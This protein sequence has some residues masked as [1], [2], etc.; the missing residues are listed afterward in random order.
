MRSIFGRCIAIAMMAAIALA[1]QSPPVYADEHAEAVGDADDAALA[2]AKA[3]TKAADAAETAAKAATK[4]ADAADESATEA[5]DASKAAVAADGSTAD[6]KAARD[7]ATAARGA[8]TAARERAGNGPDDAGDD[9]AM[10]IDSA[11]GRYL[12]ALDEAGMEKND[13]GALL[14]STTGDDAWDNARQAKAE[15][16]RL[17]GVNNSPPDTEDAVVAEQAKKDAETAQTDAETAQKDAEAHRTAARIRATF[18]AERAEVAIA[19]AGR[20]ATAAVTAAEAAVTAAEADVASDPSLANLDALETARADLEAAEDRAGDYPLVGDAGD[21]TGDETGDENGDET[22]DENGDET[23]MMPMDMGM[24]V[25]PNGVGDLLLFGYWTTQEGRGTL[26]ALTNT[27]DM[28]ANVHVRVREG[29]GSQDVGDFTVCM[30]AG[31][32]WTAAITADGTTSRLMVGNGGSCGTTSAVPADGLIIGAASGYLEAF[33]IDAM[34]GGADSLTGTATIVS[35]MGGFAS[36]YNATALVGLDAMNTAAATGGHGVKY[37]LAREG[38]VDKEVLL[39]RWTATTAMTSAVDSLTQ[40][41]LTFPGGGQP[42]KDDAITAHVFNED[43]GSNNSPRSLMLNQEVNVCTFWNANFTMN[44][45]VAFECNGGNKLLVAFDQGWFR[46]VNNT[47]GAEMDNVNAM[48]A[49]RFAAIGLQ[50]SAF[51]GETGSFD[52]SY[53]IQW[54]AYSGAGGMGAAPWSYMMDDGE[55]KM[56]YP[57]DNMAGSVEMMGMDE[58]EME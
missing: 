16:D 50:F 39:G 34:D 49:K 36:S 20:A 11:W 28:T 29:A 58:S 31:D 23:G 9:D 10:G 48:S 46:L 52:Q 8:A 4:A 26:V 53:P 21:E 37:A 7:A 13:M 6:R 30:G 2:A 42:G 57:G 32:V 55:I 24:Q 25:A 40:V 51:M 43:G 15:F 41:V 3:A 38:G 17:T 1:W 44:D 5:E 33:T 27:G 18:A 56:I 47:V 35:V 19:A 14:I 45:R 54:M 12:K 22:G